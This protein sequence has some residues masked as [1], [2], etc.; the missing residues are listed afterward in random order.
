M[1]GDTPID[2]YE[3]QFTQREASELSGVDNLTLNNWL[4]RGTWKLEKS[5]DRRLANRRLFSIA[6]IAALHAMHHCVKQI[7]LPPATAAIA[8][9]PVYE[10]MRGPNPTAGLFSA[11]IVDCRPDNDGNSL[12]VWHIFKKGGSIIGG[13]TEDWSVQGVWRDPKS[14]NLH[15]YNPHQYPDEG[16]WLPHFPCILLPT[17]KIALRIFRTCS[18]YLIEQGD[19][20][21]A[22]NND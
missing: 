12:E 19:D 6:D 4:Q 10:F 13:S 21:G 18:A 15:Q 7:D 5:K 2:P 20:G 11:S 8:A 9:L 17:S 14:G 3:V 16:A 22:R 1:D